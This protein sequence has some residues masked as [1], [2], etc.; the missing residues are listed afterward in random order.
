MSIR[1]F[2]RMRKSFILVSI[3]I[4]RMD[5]LIVRREKNQTN[6]VGCTKMLRTIPYHI[7]SIPILPKCRNQNGFHERYEEFAMIENTDK[8][9]KCY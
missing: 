7:S 9:S 1:D 3:V 2:L 6:T 8:H 4:V 5:L